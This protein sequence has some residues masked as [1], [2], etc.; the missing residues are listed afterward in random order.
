MRPEDSLPGYIH[1]H[2]TGDLKRPYWPNFRSPR[3]LQCLPAEMR[4]QPA[5]GWAGV[6]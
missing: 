2:E 5:K 4:C 1:L 6:L 3:V